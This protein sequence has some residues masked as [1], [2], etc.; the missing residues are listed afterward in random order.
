MIAVPHINNGKVCGK[1]PTAQEL[2]Q[3]IQELVEGLYVFGQ[4]P[5]SS[6]DGNH[7]GSMSC[8]LPSAYT[9]T[10]MGQT[11]LGLEY[12]I[13]SLL[14]GNVVPQKEK[15]LRLN[16]KWRKTV[17]ENPA[18]LRQLYVDHGM[19]AL[20]DDEELGPSLYTEEQQVFIR[21]PPLHVDAPL[22]ES[23]LMNHLSTGETAAQHSSHI[24]RDVFLKYLNKS[25]LGLAVGLES[26]HQDGSLI[27]FDSI[28]DIISNTEPEFTTSSPQDGTIHTHLN[29]YLQ[30]QRQFVKDKLL[31]KLGLIHDIQ[32]LQFVTFL[33][34]LLATLKQRHKVVDCERLQPRMNPDLLKTEREFPP[35]LP[36]KESR[37][38]PYTSNNHHASAKGKIIFKKQDIKV[39]KLSKEFQDKKEKILSKAMKHEKE[40]MM[41]GV[42]NTAYSLVIVRLEDFY[43]KF[44]RRIHALIQE[45]KSQIT[46]LPPLSDTRVQELLRK[47]LGPRHASKLKT[48]NSLVVPSIEKGLTGCIAA[49]LKRCTKT[50][51]N[52]PTDEDGM[53]LI[54]HAAIHGKFEIVS[55]LI[56]NAA[57]PNQFTEVIGTCPLSTGSAHL[58]AAAG[59][60]D[61]ICSLLKYRGKIDQ[62]DG[63]G[64]L[65]IHYAAFN[66]QQHVITYFANISNL[67]INCQTKDSLKRTPLLLATKNGCLDTVRLLVKFG[68][69]LMYSDT[70]DQNIIHISAL[71][72]HINILQFLLLEKPEL[73]VWQVLFEMLNADIKTRYPHA[74]ACVMDS[75]L[76]WNIDYWENA[77]DMIERLVELAKLPEEKLQLL[78]VQVIADVSNH[79]EVKE[80]LVKSNAI[81]TLVKHLTS[82]ND[83]LQSVACVV[84]SDL[85]LDDDNKPLISA[86]GG[87]K[88]LIKLLSSP[89][90]DIQLYAAA[91]IGIIATGNDQN[92]DLFRENDGLPCIITLLKSPL[93]CHQ[94]T[95]SAAIEVLYMS[96]INI[97]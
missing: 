35:F 18:D 76:R 67:C 72:N 10:F 41:I 63:Q 8:N 68:A 94:G 24:N 7:D 65:P 64:W 53:S 16:E 49:L 61:S 42:G 88:A 5:S 20:T 2:H 60:L 59:D 11:L 58:A 87:M 55:L 6:V 23:E 44:P 39:Q 52:K 62:E 97:P 9:D 85:G 22:A 92:K 36:S 14:H 3:L 47:P 30:K 21:Y 77:L 33:I 25:S 80:V 84:L 71:N 89:Q 15:R 74:S 51:I 27:V 95:A 93:D 69:E 32:L 56:H 83:R 75:L 86:N 26:V 29:E 37:W 79:S 43:P 13:K 34:P 31:S 50:R 70:S 66:N 40:A 73:Q 57:D 19:V 45:L 48:M 12:F 28:T 90:D 96:K 17:S 46:K 1:P 38:S 54:H 4:T 91:C 78:A 81:P 82:T